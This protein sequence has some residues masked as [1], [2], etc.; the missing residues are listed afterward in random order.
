MKPVAST[1]NATPP[2]AKAE[3]ATANAKKRAKT[4]NPAAHRQRAK[5]AARRNRISR[6]KRER[7]N[8]GNPGF[9]IWPFDRLR[10][11]MRNPG[12]SFFGFSAVVRDDLRSGHRLSPDCTIVS[13]ICT[14]EKKLCLNVLLR[15]KRRKIRRRN[16]LKIKETDFQQK[17]GSKS[18]F[19][20]AKIIPFLRIP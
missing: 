14:F 9:L 20:A 18:N 6:N 8:Y 5:V 15:P 19:S 13:A 16:F 1:E 12:F 10:V 3:S 4:K 11:H 7:F 17:K 2:N